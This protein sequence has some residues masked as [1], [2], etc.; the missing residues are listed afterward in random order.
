[1]REEAFIRERKVGGMGKL[2]EDI[3]ELLDRYW[4][5]YRQQ[6]RGKSSK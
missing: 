5:L 6:I 4:Q 3:G 1:M 2:K